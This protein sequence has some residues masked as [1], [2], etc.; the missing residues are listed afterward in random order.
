MSE[1]TQDDLTIL[2]EMM[3]DYGLTPEDSIQDL[4]DI[5]EESENPTHEV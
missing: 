2:R 1:E 5:I 4:M 3:E